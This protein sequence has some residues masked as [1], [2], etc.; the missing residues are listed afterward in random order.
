MCYDRI[1]AEPGTH[2]TETIEV[3]VF[4]VERVSGRESDQPAHFDL[5]RLKLLAQGRGYGIARPRAETTP[6]RHALSDG[7]AA[8]V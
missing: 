8:C 5:L 2:R 6:A 1:G 4:L 7:R 3:R